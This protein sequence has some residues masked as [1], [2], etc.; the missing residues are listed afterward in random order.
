M[1]SIDENGEMAGDGRVNGDCPFAEKVIPYLMNIKVRGGGLTR[2]S[3]ISGIGPYDV[4][5]STYS[6]LGM[7]LFD[8]L[9]T[10]GSR[11]LR[12]GELCRHLQAVESNDCDPCL[13]SQEWLEQY[14]VLDGWIVESVKAAN[15]EGTGEDERSSGS[16]A[17][18][19]EACDLSKSQT[20]KGLFYVLTGTLTPGDGVEPTQKTYQGLD[21]PVKDEEE[22]DWVPY[23]VARRDLVNE[24]PNASDHQCG[25]VPVIAVA[26]DSVEGRRMMEAFLERR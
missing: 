13:Q 2:R 11:W 16:I 4:A 3:N 12:S 23:C 25:V 7:T 8:T 15:R 6:L 5:M 21:P 14:R 19:A 17:Q 18:A 1:P 22:L 9:T 26:E 20:V 10:S 24:C